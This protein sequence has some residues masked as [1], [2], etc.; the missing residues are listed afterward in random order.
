MAAPLPEEAHHATHAVGVSGCQGI[1]APAS[2]LACSTGELLSSTA[3][4]A[5]GGWI[6]S[7]GA[8]TEAVPASCLSSTS[9]FS[10]PAV[11][12][13]A[14]GRHREEALHVARHRAAGAA[15]ANE[16]LDV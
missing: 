16:V 15:D 8:E 13:C 14:D 12:P 2:Q 3:E 10:R 6:T 1:H 11:A 9:S 7:P 4:S 5:P